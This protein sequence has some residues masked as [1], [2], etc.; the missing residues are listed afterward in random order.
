[1]NEM[2]LEER[3]D[4]QA[5]VITELGED[6]KALS[7]KYDTKTLAAMTG[8]FTARLWQMIIAKKFDTSES[9]AGQIAI[10]ADIA[11]SPM[12]NAPRIQM[13]DGGTRG[14]LQ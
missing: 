5:K 2:T 8:V 10:M 11:F 13:I 14:S 9:V 6:L 4:H 12:E 1:M 3:Q 7:I